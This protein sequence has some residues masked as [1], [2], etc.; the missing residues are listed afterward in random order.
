M[1][2]LNFFKKIKIG[3]KR[4]REPAIPYVSS[5]KRFGNAGEDGFIIL[6][7][8][9]IPSCKIKRNVVIET[10]EGNAEID[11]II[12]VNDKLFAVEIKRWKG[13]ITEQDGEF[14]QQKADRW[15]GE[16]HEKYHKS[17]FKQMGRAVYLLRKEYSCRA[18]INTVVFFEDAENVS[19]G[20]DR[21]WFDDIDNLILYLQNDGRLSQP[22]EAATLFQKIVSADYLYAKSWDKSLHCLISERSLRFQVEGK[23]IQKTDIDYIQISHHFSFDELHIVLKN[24]SSVTVNAENAKILVDDSQS[25]QEYALCKIDYIKI[26]QAI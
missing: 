12:L 13:I 4:W 9:Y 21:V 2:I 5:E 25:A 20:S 16:V 14:L 11:C 23:M 18:W 17:P 24:G 7:K 10:S 1:G 15:T 19:I 22:E 6:L 8:R 26:G 3:F